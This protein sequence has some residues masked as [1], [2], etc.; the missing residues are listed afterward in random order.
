MFVGLGFVDCY[1][2]SWGGFFSFSRP[3]TMCHVWMDVSFREGSP[4]SFSEWLQGLPV[5]CSKG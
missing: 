5:Y 4:W 1:L 2:D 3:C